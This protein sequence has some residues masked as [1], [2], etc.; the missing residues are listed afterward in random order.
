MLHAVGSSDFHFIPIRNISAAGVWEIQIDV[1]NLS[2]SI[3]Q[4]ELQIMAI[5]RAKDT[6]SAQNALLRL[7]IE[8]PTDFCPPGAP[9]S[10]VIQTHRETAGELPGPSAHESVPSSPYCTVFE[11]RRESEIAKDLERFT[12]SK[13]L[14]VS[15]NHDAR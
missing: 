11:H 3:S 4:N 8:Y 13:R 9:I 6:T 1:G 12:R 15:V 10:F 7:L 5:S 2:P 14:A